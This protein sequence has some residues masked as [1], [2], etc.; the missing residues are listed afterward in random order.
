MSKITIQRV[1]LEA[2]VSKGTVSRVLNARSGVNEET[3]VLVQ[4]VVDRLGYVPDPGARQLA[5]RGRHVIGLM[6]DDDLRRGGTYYGILRDALEDR[7]SSEGYHTQVFDSD[8][9]DWLETPPDGIILLGVHLDDPRPSLLE[10]QRVPFVMIGRSLLNKAWVDVDNQGGLHDA[11]RHLVALGH[12]RIA[13]ITGA[14]T[15]QASVQRLAGYTAGLEAAH[16]EVDDALIWDGRFHRARRVTRA[17]RRALKSGVPFT[18]IAAASDE[19]AF[20]AIGALEDAGMRVPWDVSVTGFD[21]L[22]IATRIGLTTAR[23]PIQSIGK[24]AAELLLER[25][26]GKAARH[27][28]IQTNLVVRTSSAALLPVSAAMQPS[29][30]T[31]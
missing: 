18:A 30:N 23:Q 14:H 7:F 6:L 2:G 13:H 27:Q 16:L 25:M 15:G 24:C 11:V 28:L 20:G 12:R 19:M 21:D 17:V 1:A 10:K 31:S 8:S 3:R 4:S 22:P 29:S 5:R 26:A 9:Q